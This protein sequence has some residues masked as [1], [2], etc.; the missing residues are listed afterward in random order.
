M[1]FCLGKKKCW[2]KSLPSQYLNSPRHFFPLT[3]AWK[4]FAW[5][6]FKLTKQS[7]W[8][9][10][11]NWLAV[12]ANRYPAGHFMSNQQS[13][14]LQL[15]QLGRDASAAVSRSHC[16]LLKKKKAHGR[17]ILP[18]SCFHFFGGCFSG[19]G[20]TFEHTKEACGNWISWRCW[21]IWFQPSE[22]VL[23]ARGM[24]KKI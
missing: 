12:S 3:Y 9:S 16:E 21:K 24:K 2:Y 15:A 7:M 4:C 5:Q 19:C 13:L 1:C 14:G 10:T 23:P 22:E 18:F 17:I 6:G 20:S 11:P 8:R